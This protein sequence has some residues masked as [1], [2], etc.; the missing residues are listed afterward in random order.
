MSSE[1]LAIESVNRHIREARQRFVYIPDAPG[2]DEWDTVREFEGRRGGDCDGWVLWTLAE[3]YREVPL[4]NFYHLVAGQ[5]HTRKG[6]VGHA[7]G[8]LRL[9]DSRLWCDPTWGLSV[10]SIGCFSG[11]TPIEAYPIQGLLLGPAM[12]YEP[13]P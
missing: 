7:W 8:E 5:V 2:V 3:S 1:G 4:K 13:S 6:V 12:R 10:A 9:P 11:R